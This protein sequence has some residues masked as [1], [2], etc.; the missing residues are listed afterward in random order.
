MNL[1][2]KA[3]V[4][5]VLKPR[6]ARDEPGK[7]VLQLGALNLLP[8][9]AAPHMHYIDQAM[10][11]LP[12]VTESHTD[13]SGAIHVTYGEGG[14]AE[15]LRRWVDTAVEEAISLTEGKD[16]RKISEKELVEGELARLRLLVD[17][18]A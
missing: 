15:K 13:S 9:D 7:C 14:S 4:R 5:R 10:T 3:L 11:L 1:I 2:E 17:K 16:I 6:I 18:Y 8:I 12:W